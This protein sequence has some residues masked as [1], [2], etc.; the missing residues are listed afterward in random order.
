MASSHC[1][2][3]CQSA[4]DSTPAAQAPTDAPADATDSTLVVPSLAADSIPDA[5]TT[6]TQIPAQLNSLVPSDP[7]HTVQYISDN[8]WPSTLILN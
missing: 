4:S 1:M 2:A 8:A 5:S 7:L 3:T 6:S